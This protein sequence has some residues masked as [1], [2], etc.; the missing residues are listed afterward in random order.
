MSRME[1][2]PLNP[3]ST[4]PAEDVG[5]DTKRRFRHQACYTAMVS[6]G[7]LDD[8]GPLP[9]ATGKDQFTYLDIGTNIDCSA[10]LQDDGRF[11]LQMALERSS[12]APDTASSTGNPVVRNLR[13]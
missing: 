11:K 12:I 3:A 4:P 1:K 7:L 6:L 8:E 2:P 5:A 10:T 13:V 9:L